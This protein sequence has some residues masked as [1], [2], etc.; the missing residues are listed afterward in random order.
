MK[1]FTFFIFLFF[2]V[3]IFSQR[4]VEIQGLDDTCVFTS[5]RANMLKQAIDS[6]AENRKLAP[7]VIYRLQRGKKYFVSNSISNIDFHL[8]LEA[9][10]G[11][12][13]KPK[14]LAAPMN[15]GRYQEMFM[16]RNNTILKNLHINCKQ[17]TTNDYNN[18]N[19][20]LLGKGKSYVFEGVDCEQDR[21][22]FLTTIAD[23]VKLYANNCLIGN[24]GLPTSWAGNGRF[25]DHR[26]KYADTI[27]ITNC[28]AFDVAD[29][30]LSTYNKEIRYFK[31]DHVTVF[32]SP[33]NKGC[34]QLGRT[35]KIHI[36]NN[37]FYNTVLYGNTH[38]RATTTQYQ[39]EK[40]MHVITLDTVYSD[41][42]A[43]IR[44]NNITWDKEYLD[45]Y[46][47]SDT[48]SEPWA[49]TQTL[50][51]LLKTDSAKAFY[52][53]ILTFKNPAPS[54]INFIQE[55]YKQPASNSLPSAWW[56]LETRSTLYMVDFSYDRNSKSFTAA[57][58]GRPVG[59]LRWNE[60][61]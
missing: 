53:E 55:F 29:R 16:L 34:V 44:N 46:A 42:Q 27:V 8:V 10:K 22:A 51:N 61:K 12:G 30:F 33:G 15:D 43:E 60:G 39:P 13:P 17:P 5:A 49:L 7:N 25:V 23:S 19:I 41:T 48:V 1:L 26:T 35:H 37:L 50:K 24:M 4:V 45:Y 21:G 58:G 2:T 20:K 52:S 56:L 14:L 32:N 28:T 18:R 11:A 9:N 36:T 54:M 38:F 40:Y 47:K 6:D 57:D 3:P 31:M 59:D